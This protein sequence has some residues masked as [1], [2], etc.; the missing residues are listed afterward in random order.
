[1]HSTTGA[2]LYG[3]RGPDIHTHR[4]EAFVMFYFVKISYQYC[5]KKTV[6]ISIMNL[7]YRACLE[8]SFKLQLLASGKEN[9]FKRKVDQFS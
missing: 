8:S 7:F 2:L 3:N 4:E 5:D 1:M 6:R 9:L